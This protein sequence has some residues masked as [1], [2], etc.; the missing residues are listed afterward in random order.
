MA[1]LPYQT[2]LSINTNYQ[3]TPRHRLVEFGDG[4]IQRTPL[5]I[6]YQ[7]RSISVRHD[8][9]NA[10]QAAALILFYEA[11]LQDAD[12]IDISAN[13]LLRTSG[14]FYLESFDVQMADN[15]RRT[16]TASMIEVFDL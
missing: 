12:K 11:R 9:L 8:N 1:T 2:Q 5:G 13:E 3:A 4:Y 6:N 7:R 15:E 16:V 14:Q 10:T